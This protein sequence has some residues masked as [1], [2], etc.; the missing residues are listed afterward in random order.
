METFAHPVIG[1]GR[2]TLAIRVKDGVI[3]CG[4][5]WSSIRDQF[6]RAKGRNL[7]TPRLNTE[8]PKDDA[9]KAFFMEGPFNED[10]KIAEQAVDMLN[11]LIAGHKGVPGWAKRAKVAKLKSRRKFEAVLDVEVVEAEIVEDLSVLEKS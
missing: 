3:S 2:A 6:C 10:R 5:A 1:K 8:N 9:N 4:V 7:A 11:N